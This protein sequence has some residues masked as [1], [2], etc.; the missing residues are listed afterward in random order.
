MVVILDP[1][2][3]RQFI[4]PEDLKLPVEERT[5]WTIRGLTAR[6]MSWLRDLQSGTDDN[7]RIGATMFHRFRLGV[8]GWEN[9]RLGT[10]P[11]MF[12]TQE[13]DLFGRKLT[14]VHDDVMEMIPDPL[15]DVVQ[16]EVQRLSRLV[17]EDVKSAAPSGAPG[18]RQ[19][20]DGLPQVPGT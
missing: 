1:R 12:K 15:L 5:I 20:P 14:V 16:A 4:I 18:D 11:L 7:Y 6:E 3:P 19:A 9:L 8:M 13:V 10:A 2:R 17:G